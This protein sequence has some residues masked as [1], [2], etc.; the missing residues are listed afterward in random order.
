MAAKST[1]KASHRRL[2]E[3]FDSDVSA[4][5]LDALAGRLNET[6]N[7]IGFIAYS[8]EASEDALSARAAD[9]PNPQALANWTVDKRSDLPSVS[10]GTIG[11]LAVFLDDV[12]GSAGELLEDVDR[13]QSSL[14][15]LWYA[16]D[17]L[18][19][20]EAEADRA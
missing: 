1:R 7:R 19:R 11:R 9:E 17:L 20:I 5:N 12:R 18:D 15:D 16:S 3:R 2:V 13:I 6:V 4:E 10:H 8:V 14:S